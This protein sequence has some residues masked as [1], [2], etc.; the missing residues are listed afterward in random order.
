M[1][2]AKGWVSEQLNANLLIKQIHLDYLGLRDIKQVPSLLCKVPALLLARTWADK[3]QERW[4]QA[5]SAS[6]NGPKAAS[7]GHRLQTTALARHS[8]GELSLVKS[9]GCSG[10]WAEGLAGRA[11]HSSSCCFVGAQSRDSSAQPALLSFI[12]SWGGSI[13]H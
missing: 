9:Q 4:I 6:C 5:R 1:F 2:Q 11:G 10:C 13:R 7:V 8:R 12:P 3:P